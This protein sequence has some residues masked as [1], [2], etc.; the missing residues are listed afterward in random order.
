MAYAHGAESGP[1]LP[2][3]PFSEFLRAFWA[4]NPHR[5]PAAEK[6]VLYLWQVCDAGDTSLLSE[7]VF[8]QP[9]IE[10]NAFGFEYTQNCWGRPR[11]GYMKL[12]SA[13]FEE[14]LD[15]DDVPARMATLACST[16]LRSR[17]R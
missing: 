9:Y 11:E 4:E 3:G 2:P 10:R 17:K 1:R 7:M 14:A 5:F 13:G 8:V 15:E 16:R 6:D 12:R